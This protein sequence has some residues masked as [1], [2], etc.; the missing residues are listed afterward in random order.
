[1]HLLRLAQVPD[2]L[3]WGS[4]LTAAP[5]QAYPQADR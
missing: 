3:S 1:M 5:T 4:S 2:L